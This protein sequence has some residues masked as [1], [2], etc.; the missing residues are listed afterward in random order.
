MNTLFKKIALP[1]RNGIIFIHPHNLM[2]LEA[3]GGYTSIYLANKEKITVARSLGQFEEILPPE[4][5][6]RVHRAYIINH[7][8]I[9]KYYTGRGGH[10]ELE[11]GTIVDVSERKK[12]AFL[13]KF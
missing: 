1:E 6:S 8:F 9:R 10:L 5:F 3:S 2:L 7:N 11:D 12:G 13:S 4:L